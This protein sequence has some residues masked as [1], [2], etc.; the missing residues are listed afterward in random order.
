MIRPDSRAPTRSE[1]ERW[2]TVSSGLDERAWSVDPP[3]GD[4]STRKYFRGR[5]PRDAT[6]IVAWY[7]PDAR[8]THRRYQQASRLL[9]TAGVRVPEIL[10]S[11]EAGCYMVLED[12]GT[13]RLFDLDP[14]E[15]RTVRLFGSAMDLAA[16]IGG[17]PE[18]AVIQLNPPLDRVLFEREL[19]QT[20]RLFLGERLPSP[21]AARA[22]DALA[23]LC[24]DLDTGPRVAC[25]R[26]FMARN[27]MV[28]NDS[29][30]VIDHQ[31]LRA[32]PAG[33][34][35]AS[36]FYDS[37]RLD[38]GARRSLELGAGPACRGERYHRLVVQRMLKIVGTFHAFARRGAPQYLPMVPEALA[39]ALDHLG[40]LP[41][42]DELAQALRCA[43]A[44]GR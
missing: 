16:R 9:E 38:P 32:G 30:V 20:W 5:S 28:H 13:R 34:D 1:V 2:L 42:L 25:H 41:G 23:G 8:S 44:A 24:R 19:D 14:E 15:E 31:D 11:D 43:R 21:L 6:V 36:L 33:Y 39:H 37:C 26:D 4:V 27:L 7:P 22:R 10:A 12:V 29:L 40:A 3:I 18:A 17:L 35:L